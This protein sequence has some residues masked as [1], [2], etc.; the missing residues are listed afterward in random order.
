MSVPQAHV[1]VRPL[2]SRREGTLPALEYLL[3]L[4]LLLLKELLQRDAG[5]QKLYQ[6]GSDVG[7]FRLSLLHP[8]RPHLP[9]QE[10]RV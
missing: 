6:Q 2:K 8:L 10:L 3:E 5:L 7:F 1:S 9:L 4:L